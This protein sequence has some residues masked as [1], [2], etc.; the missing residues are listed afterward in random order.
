MAFSY[1]CAWSFRRI[2]STDSVVQCTGCGRYYLHGIV[3]RCVGRNCG[4]GQW[5]TVAPELIPASAPEA[6][7][8]RVPLPP[9][10]SNRINSIN[11]RP[12]GIDGDMF[13]FEQADVREAILSPLTCQVSVR[14]NP[15]PPSPGS[16]V[17]A[18]NNILKVPVS[19]GPLWLAMHPVNSDQYSAG[20]LLL[21]PGTEARYELSVHFYHPPEAIVVIPM[22]EN[23]DEPH[24]P[25]LHVLVQASNL[26]VHLLQCVTWY[27]TGL[28]VWTVYRVA[29]SGAT[30]TDAA[31]TLAALAAW[32]V[33]LTPQLLLRP[34][35]S[36]RMA[37]AH[38]VLTVWLYD[39]LPLPRMLKRIGLAAAAGFAARLLVPLIWIISVEFQ[40]PSGELL[41]MI[42]TA[43]AA[44]AGSVLWQAHCG[45][46]W[47]SEA[48][49][50]FR[51]R[52]PATAG[53]AG[54]ATTAQPTADGKSAQN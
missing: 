21:P 35:L 31:R 50:L 1:R 17:P 46:D 4:N 13:L 20:A 30:T 39:R 54:K 27:L 3:G 23:S 8:T 40:G 25:G 2:C 47:L 51:R 14:H 49:R 38:R 41:A 22:L 34:M 32:A 10:I 42:G 52:K 28:H 29:E 9:I 53:S 18:T 12:L 19:A 5:Q 48:G 43:I 26:P 6:A 15:E 24:P 36:L 45:V 16:A 37:A 7:Q 33:L 44:V 11:D